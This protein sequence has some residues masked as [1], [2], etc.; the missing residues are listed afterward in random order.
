MIRRRCIMIFYLNFTVFIKTG[1]KFIPEYFFWMWQSTFDN[2]LI[3]TRRNR[4][5]NIPPF[6]IWGT[7][8]IST[9]LPIWRRFHIAVKLQISYRG[10][11]LYY[12]TNLPRGSWRFK[13]NLKTIVSPREWHG[14]CSIIVGNIF[15]E[16]T[17]RLIWRWKN[18]KVK[19]YLSI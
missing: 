18:R 15:N 7:K 10:D 6:G 17:C 14:R 16:P 11:N 1:D 3:S 19:N 5:S 13:N 12:G 4:T 8:N 9:I 2:E